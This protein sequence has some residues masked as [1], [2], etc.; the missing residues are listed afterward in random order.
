MAVTYVKKEC[1]K[2]T[3]TTVDCMVRFLHLADVHLDTAFEGRSDALRTHLQEALRI[4]FRRAVDCAID[5]DVH[6]VLIAGDLF[7]DDRLSVATEAFLVDQIERLT[8]AGIDVVYATGNHDPGGQGFRA[9][10]ID[11]PAGF[12]YVDTHTPTPIE[13][14]GSDESPRATVVAAG[15]V[16]SQEETNLAAQFPDAD[17]DVPHVALL[18]AHVTSA[19]QVEAHD[20]YAP[21]T[22]EDLQ[23]GG[24]DYWALGHIH[25][26][27]QV[28][29]DPPAWYPG[30]LQG[31]TPRETGARGGLLVTLRRNQE[32]EVTFRPFAPTRWEHLQLDDLEDVETVQALVQRIRSTHREKARTATATDWL[33]RVDLSGPCP[34]ADRLSTSDQ[35]DELEQVTA[36]RLD[37]RD[38]EIRTQQLTPPVDVEAFRDDTHL[39]SELL[40]LLD[41]AYT[42]DEVLDT[43]APDALAGLADETPKARRT[44]LR[45]LLKGLD[46]E[47]VARLVEEEGHNQ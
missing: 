23:A 24:Y 20:R 42:Q 11:W 45:S 31:R 35:V 34:L 39:V 6:A 2:L 3:V 33:L 7:D 36:E 37:V 47:A 12:H 18:H 43:V 27:Q 19:S 25:T 13:L 32:P 44:Y 41:A 8:D 4:A 26:R 28:H 15:H 46:R 14:T 38:V 16:A 29:E 30:N 5:E 17:G 22:V 9:A 21:C 40:D 10:K 1:S